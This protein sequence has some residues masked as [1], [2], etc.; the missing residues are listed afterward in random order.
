MQDLLSNGSRVVA[1]GCHSAGEGYSVSAVPMI[2]Q[3]Q[4]PAGCESQYGI[5]LSEPTRPPL[6]T[7]SAAHS[8][9]GTALEHAN[10]TGHRVHAQAQLPNPVVP[11]SNTICATK[12]TG[13]H[14]TGQPITFVTSPAHAT[15][16][17]STEHTHNRVPSPGHLHQVL[18]PAQQ[19]QQQLEQHQQQQQQGNQQQQQQHKAPGEQEKQATQANKTGPRSQRG[20]KQT[21]TTKLAVIQSPNRQNAREVD[22][23]VD[24]TSS[25]GQAV[26]QHMAESLA[27]Q[28]HLTQPDILLSDCSCIPCG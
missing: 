13:K 17:Y 18:H 19:T 23:A 15:H 7:S 28:L 4:R 21:V 1:E 20:R 8:K 9:Q 24:H 27:G 16:S 22:N 3:P 25:P 2:S 11:D 5:A 12:L 6:P 26:S 14:N 10:S